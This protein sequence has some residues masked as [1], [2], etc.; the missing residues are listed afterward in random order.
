MHDEHYL[1]VSQ[2]DGYV[3]GYDARKFDAPIFRKQAHA[4][5]V[6]SVSLHHTDKRVMATSSVDGKVRIWDISQ[7]PLL[8]DEKKLEVGELFSC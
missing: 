4:K 6:T 3:S 7:G 2:E 1:V 8:I 5:N